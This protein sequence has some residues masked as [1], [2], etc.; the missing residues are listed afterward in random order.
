[1]IAAAAHLGSNVSVNNI[2][3]GTTY[4]LLPGC[5]RKSVIDYSSHIA[6]A[7]FVKIFFRELSV[8][9]IAHDLKLI[10]TVLL[11]SEE[12]K[13]LVA[14]YPESGLPDIPVHSRGYRTD[15]PAVAVT[16]PD[17]FADDFGFRTVPEFIPGL[18]VE[19]A[20]YFLVLGP[21]A[22]HDVAVRINEERVK[23]HIARKKSLLPVDIIDESVVEICSE[24]LLR[25]V[26]IQKLVDQTL[27]LLGNLRAVM[28]D[29]LGL[30]KIE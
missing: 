7:A 19:V 11:L 10:H 24:P 9:V 28:D 17:F 26:G 18:L 8:A 2:L 6:G 5:L 4:K 16:V 15:H 22:G 14:H 30:D 12:A 3:A 25:A 29:I 23:T 27:E 13:E 21:I 1:M 20:H